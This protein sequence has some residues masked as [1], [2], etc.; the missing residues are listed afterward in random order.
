MSHLI[1]NSNQNGMSHVNV[2]NIGPSRKTKPL[3][4]LYIIKESS[5]PQSCSAVC[6]VLIVLSRLESHLLSIK[7]ER[8][9]LAQ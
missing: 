7:A 9:D 1:S 4:K 6:D 5:S 8:V 3:K 2:A